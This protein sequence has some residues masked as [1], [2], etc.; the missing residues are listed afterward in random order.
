MAA[1]SSRLRIV[2]CDN[3]IEE[4]LERHREE[5]EVEILQ[6]FLPH[7]FRMNSRKK[8]EAEKS[9]LVYPRPYV[10]GTFPLYMTVTLM[11]RE[12][13][14]RPIL[15]NAGTWDKIYRCYQATDLDEIPFEF[16]EAPKS[17][18]FIPKSRKERGFCHYFK[19]ISPPVS[20]ED[21][22]LC[23]DFPCN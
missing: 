5:K 17:F 19:D 21:G 7:H 11:Y 12:P 3:P 2:F 8:R 9:K 14:W 20:E 15:C 18:A 10:T 16:A 6:I 23:T 22:D 1:P 13:W 4:A